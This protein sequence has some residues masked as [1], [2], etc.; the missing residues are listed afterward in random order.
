MELSLAPLGALEMSSDM[1]FIESDSGSVSW[2]QRGLEVDFSSIGVSSAEG[3]PLARVHEFLP[4][5]EPYQDPGGGSE[6]GGGPASPGTG[7][8]AWV[9]LPEAMEALR[10]A[11]TRGQLGQALLSYAQGRFPRGFLLGETF[12]ALRVGL[13]CGA[14]SDKP[15]VA[16][17]KMD[18]SAPSLLAQAASDGGPVVSSMP[19]SRAD[20]ALFAALGESFSHLVAAP[21]R[22]RQ[23]AVGFVV[24]DGGPSPFAAE[25]LDELERLLA[26]ASEAYGRLHES[27]F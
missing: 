3:V 9:P 17:L 16:A 2:A 8:E 10:R 21:I 14:G 15:E 22:L 7:E 5:W 4:F 20:E 24:I 25:E 27:S 6:G 18:L 26:A 12:G 23:R 19:E 11:T 13:A 1:D